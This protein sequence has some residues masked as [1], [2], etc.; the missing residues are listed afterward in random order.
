MTTERHTDYTARYETVKNSLPGHTHPWVT[1][2]REKALK[3]FVET[4][5]PTRKTESWKYTNTHALQQQLFQAPQTISS[6]TLPSLPTQVQGHDRVVFING[7]FSSELSQL[8]ED[9]NAL[10]VLP[11]ETA[12]NTHTALVKDALQNSAK[13]AFSALNTA[14]MQQGCFIS[15][16]ENVQ[17]TAP[18]HLVYLT[19]D[20]SNE[21]TLRNIIVL[22]EHAHATV[23]E[24]YCSETATQYFNNTMTTISLGEKATLSH[25]KLIQEASEA[26]HIGELHVQQAAHSIFTGFNFSLS[27]KLGRTD[28]HIKQEGPHAETN[29]Y[30]LYLGKDSSH[31]DNQTRISHHSTH[32]TSQEYYKGI[33][34]DRA[35]AVF[36][37]TIHGPPHAHK[38]AATL[39]N[40]NIVLSPTAVI[41]TKPDLEVF[42]DD[43]KCNHG[44]TIGQLDDDASFYLRSRGLS[45]AAAYLLLLRAFADEVTLKHPCDAIHTL[46]NEQVSTLIASTTLQ[47][48]IS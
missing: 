9:N 13:N 22:H 41:N 25:T 15:V 40:K 4:G 10:I 34:A 16:G 42:A 30:G 31:T 27:G 21:S 24:T 44:A 18:L 38:T 6:G 23:V 45:K 3:Q 33:V 11:L 48:D 2:L 20:N 35:V 19:T 39:L 1:E 12:L 28:T 32:G 26:F 47:K 37:G 46:V 5:F 43:V 7:L 29:L 14:F 17:L 36:N 8:P